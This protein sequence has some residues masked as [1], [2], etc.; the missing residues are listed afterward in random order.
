MGEAP[1]HVLT[2]DGFDPHQEG[3]REAI[4]ALGNGVFVS[5]AACSWSR[6]D[7][8]HYPGTYLAGGYDRLT[9]QIAGRDVENEDLVNLP[10]WLPVTFRL[11]DGPW[12]RG[13]ADNV[14]AYRL[15]LDIH[16]ITKLTLLHQCLAC[17]RGPVL[18]RLST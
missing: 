8:V 7:D 13:G 14:R 3:L 10:N 9:T 6:A 4:C 12:F 16:G 1:R 2:Y 18:P 11:G 15:A 5:R 17:R